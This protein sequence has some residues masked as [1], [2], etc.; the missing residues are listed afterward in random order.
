MKFIRLAK[1]PGWSEDQKFITRSGPQIGL[2]KIA[3]MQVMK[4]RIDKGNDQ[5]KYRLSL[6]KIQPNSL[7]YDK[8]EK[9]NEVCLNVR[10]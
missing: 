4:F 6:I 2:P 5:R 8:T 3:T 1:K 10:M 7:I 9:K